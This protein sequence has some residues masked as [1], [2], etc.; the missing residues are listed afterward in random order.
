MGSTFVISDT[1]FGHSNMLT[2]LREDGQPLRAFENANAMDEYMI[3]R[4][5]SVVS[6]GDRVYHLG[7]L[8]FSK[9]VLDAVMP[10]L[11]GKPV[12]IKGNHDMLKLKDYSR[13]FDDIRSYIVRPRS[14]LI[15]S[16]YPI[17][18][19]SLKE[20]WM[21]VHGHTHDRIVR[22]HNDDADYRYLNVSVEQPWMNYTPISIEEL[23]EVRLRRLAEGVL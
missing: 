7:D 10:R 2:F 14:G 13:H 16:H 5:N 22:D 15:L 20:S 9:H 6:S 23:V 18:T 1:H 12:L 19:A 8:T 4:W 11:N 17:H 21:N 3:E